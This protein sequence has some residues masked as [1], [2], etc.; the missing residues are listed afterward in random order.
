MSLHYI[1]GHRYNHQGASGKDMSS[2]FN[3]TITEWEY[4]SSLHQYLD[5]PYKLD[6]AFNLQDIKPYIT[7]DTLG[8]EFHLNSFNSGVSG[9]EVLILPNDARSLEA[10]NLFL[11]IMKKLFPLRR[12]RGIKYIT[13]A[14][15]GY[16]NLLRLKQYYKQAMITEMF[17]LDNSDDWMT[18]EESALVINELNRNLNKGGK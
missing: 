18:L 14:D 3:T 17:F 11:G 2:K 4:S 12:N 9:Y 5:T 16:N 7:D 6:D 8:L 15:R 1:N 10:A 13:H